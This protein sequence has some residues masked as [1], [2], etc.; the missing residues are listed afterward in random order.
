MSITAAKKADLFLAAIIDLDRTADRARKR[1]L[2][3]C[4]EGRL[5]A[6]G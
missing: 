2:A 5:H 3:D 1:L 6:T 4:H